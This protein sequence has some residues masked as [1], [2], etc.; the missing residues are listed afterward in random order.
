VYRV[1]IG[2]EQPSQLRTVLHPFAHL[3]FGLGEPV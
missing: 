3:G 1:A 2:V